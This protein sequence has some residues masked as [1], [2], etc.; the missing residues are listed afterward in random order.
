[1]LQWASAQLIAV[2]GRLQL[3]L[4][5]QFSLL[6]YT[7]TRE[8]I[9][10]LRLIMQLDNENLTPAE[11]LE[12]AQRLYDIGDANMY[13]ASILEAITALEAYVY[14]QAFP[15]LQAKVGEELAKWLEERTRMDFETRIG[16]FIPVATGLKVDKKDRLWIDYK[17]AK[18]IRNRVT[19]SGRKVTR[20]QA[21]FVIDTIYEWVE[22]LKQAQEAQQSQDAR[23]R[24]S[25]E[26]LGRFIQASSRLE[27]VIY[28]AIKKY[29]PHQELSRRQVYSVEELFRFGLI[30]E[31]TLQELNQLRALR[32]RAVHSP[33]GSRLEV[34]ERHISRLDQIVDDIDRKIR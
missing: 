32:N 20:L 24:V 16:L 8:L 4:L 12:T 19:H 23:D 13:R 30:D 33:P 15:A 18:E 14:S 3:A 6:I 25:P 5:V 10:V 29:N 1:M 26:M 7:Y 2:V 31:N 27:R 22:Y 21:R 17:K 9:D 28:S 11:L 34:T